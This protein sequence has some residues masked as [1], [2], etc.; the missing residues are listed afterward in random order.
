ML[1][2]FSCLGRIPVGEEDQVFYEN[3]PRVYNES[4][5]DVWDA[6]VEVAEKLD[7]KIASVDEKTG[8][9]V[10]APSYV[11]KSKRKMVDRVYSKPPAEELENSIVMTH[12]KRVSYFEKATPKEA[13]PHPIYT[14][15]YL[16]I[17]VKPKGEEKT[18]VKVDYKIVPYF[19]YKIGHLGAVRSKGYLE[20]G[21]YN[22][23]S[24]LLSA[25]NVPPPLLPPVRSEEIYQL[26]DVFFDFDKYEIRP[27]AKAVLLENLETIRKHPELNIVIQGYADIR[28]TVEYN[29]ELSKKRAQAVK[30]FLVENG[31]NRRRIIAVGKGETL[32]FAPGTTE[33]EYQLNRRAHFITVEVSD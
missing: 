23:I 13:P 21:I 26:S 25:K 18:Q 5:S 14:K 15:E 24:E 28:G 17:T 4:Y 27:D 10:F 2:M 30:N 19:D 29:R 6:A 32:R 20:E 33:R 11:Y 16:R 7:W 8:R 12:L 9:I 3:K 31:I 1:F 22:Q